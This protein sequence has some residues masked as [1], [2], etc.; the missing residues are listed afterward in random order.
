[1]GIEWFVRVFVRKNYKFG[2]LGLWLLKILLVY[3]LLVLG[4][5][6]YGFLILSVLFF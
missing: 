2:W 3:Y 1:M 5:E 6:V 4:I